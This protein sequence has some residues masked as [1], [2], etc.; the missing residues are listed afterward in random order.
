MIIYELEKLD[1]LNSLR[2]NYNYIANWHIPESWDSLIAT[3]WRNGVPRHHAHI[4]P[5]PPRPTPHLVLGGGLVLS[6][7]LMAFFASTFMFHF[8]KKSTYVP[9][10]WKLCIKFWLLPSVVLCYPNLQK[11]RWT[12]TSH[13]GD[14]DSRN[15]TWK[16]YWRVS[17]AVK[18]YRCQRPS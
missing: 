1:V 14:L 6:F 12:G 2:H 18:R 17:Q 10:R 15:L 3:S 4:A 8:T 13:F 5:T 16:S 9:S 11:T 7:F